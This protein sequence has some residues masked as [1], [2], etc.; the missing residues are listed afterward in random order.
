[1]FNNSTSDFFINWIINDF[2]F[3]DGHLTAKIQTYKIRKKLNDLEKKKMLVNQLKFSKS[4]YG[5]ETVARFFFRKKISELN[6]NELLF[7]LANIDLFAES[8]IFNLNQMIEKYLILLNWLNRNNPK[9]SEKF[10]DPNTFKITPELP[11]DINLL[12]KDSNLD[13]VN[14]GIALDLMEFYLKDYMINHLNFTN[15]M[16]GGY[17]IKSSFDINFLKT[18]IQKF[19]ITG[20]EKSNKICI[21]YYMKNDKY[22][23]IGIIYLPFGK[24]QITIFENKQDKIFYNDFPVNFMVLPILRYTFIEMFDKNKIA[25]L[26]LTEFLKNSNY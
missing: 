7:C 20:G 22:Y 19:N 8:D 23:M 4:I 14:S 17:N 26:P 15:L 13:D 6:N 16:S 5:I 3:F 12:Q 21:I 2:Y 11:N 18:I 24:E 1:M 9:L 25:I 10:K